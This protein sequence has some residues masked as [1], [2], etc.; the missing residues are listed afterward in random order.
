FAYFYSEP[1]RG[2]VVIVHNPR[3]ECRT[4][5][6]DD[7]NCEDLI[8]RVIAL[9][10]EYV[11]IKEGR[12]YIN[13]GHDPIQEPYIKDFCQGCD[14]SWILDSQHYFI[15]GDNRNNSWDSHAFG[16]IP[17][18]LI[19]GQAWIRYWPLQDEGLIPHPTYDDPA[20]APTPVGTSESVPAQ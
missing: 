19:V 11:Q 10:G 3:Q 16:P 13:N 17:R 15:L 6:P 7:P 5:A 1:Q 2:D 20:P 18:D 9:P 12:V 4:A 14:G 8:K